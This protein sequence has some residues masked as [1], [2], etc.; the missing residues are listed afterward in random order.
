[1]QDET[2]RSLI[3]IGLNAAIVAVVDFQPMIFCIPSPE[4]S[5]LPSL[6][7]GP[8]DPLHHRTMEIGLRG[9][10]KEQAGLDLGYIEQLYTFGDRGRHRSH[11]DDEPHVVSV[12]YLALTRLEGPGPHDNVGMWRKLV[13]ISTLGRLAAGQTAFIG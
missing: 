2:R 13:S 6:P 5:S 9:W 7:F 10:V 1:M 4:D 11:D 12:G 8:F 3:E